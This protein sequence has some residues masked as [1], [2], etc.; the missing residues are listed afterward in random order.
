MKWPRAIKQFTVKQA[1][2]THKFFA[3]IKRDKNILPLRP[4]NSAIPPGNFEMHENE[5]CSVP[6]TVTRVTRLANE[7]YLPSI[8]LFFFKGV[9]AEFH[10][11]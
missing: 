2:L 6:K 8:Q 7:R 11:F 4:T 1:S 9:I 5:N 10:I 3:C